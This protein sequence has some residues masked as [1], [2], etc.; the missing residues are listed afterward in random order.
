MGRGTAGDASP[1]FWLSTGQSRLPRDFVLAA[2]VP[3]LGD[4]YPLACLAAGKG[5]E[6]LA[7]SNDESADASLAPAI[8]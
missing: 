1:W 8:S 5:L 2:A 7:N 6:D 4:E 3:S